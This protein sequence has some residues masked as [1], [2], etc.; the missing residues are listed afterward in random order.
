[1]N[2][3]EFLGGMLAVIAVPKIVED[4]DWDQAERQ[5]WDEA[6]LLQVDRSDIFAGLMQDGGEVPGVAR[7]RVGFNKAM[8]GVL[9]NAARV[10][11]PT[12][13]ASATV[14]GLGL[15]DAHGN[16]LF[17]GATSRRMSVMNGDAISF[18]AGSIAVTLT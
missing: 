2:R 15:Y 9:T 17:T 3:R 5:F 6:S 4:F 11:F 18:P 16:E 12:F 14:D 13:V 1:M 10:V 8:D 7:Q